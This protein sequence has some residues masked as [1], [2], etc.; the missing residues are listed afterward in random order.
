MGSNPYLTLVRLYTLDFYFYVHQTSHLAHLRDKPRVRLNPF[1]ALLMSIE[2]IAGLLFLAWYGYRTVWHYPLILV[3]IGFPS[4]L[5]LTTIEHA[6]KL[7]RNAW[8]ISISG[9]VFVPVLL[10][11]MI[12]NI[13][14]AIG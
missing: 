8:V 9:I 13:N 2:Q 3:A 12:A 6:M 14:A 10:Y 1:L 5:I 4:T 11:L 7:H